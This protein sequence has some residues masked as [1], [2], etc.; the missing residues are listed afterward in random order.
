[1]AKLSL[2]NPVKPPCKKDCPR[3]VVGCHAQ[4]PDWDEYVKRRDKEYEK[5]V[6]VKHIKDAIRDGYCRIAGR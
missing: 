1:M 2:G 4:C 5:R 6:D 3:R